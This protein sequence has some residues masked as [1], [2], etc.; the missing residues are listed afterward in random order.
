[1]NS[2]RKIF[3]EDEGPQGLKTV[4]TFFARRK[5]EY[6]IQNFNHKTSIGSSLVKGI[7]DSFQG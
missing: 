2:S 6:M 3:E 5:W 7:A 4:M 1:M